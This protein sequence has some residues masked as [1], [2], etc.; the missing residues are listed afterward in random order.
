MQQTKLKH[1]TK[2]RTTIDTFKGYDHR[3]VIQDGS[4]YDEQNLSADQYPLLTVRK[5]RG[6]V[7]MID[8]VGRTD[9]PE[10]LALPRTVA[11]CGKEELL[12]LDEQG[13]LWSNNH[14]LAI[15]GGDY[16]ILV[17]CLGGYATVSDETKLLGALCAESG[18]GKMWTED[19]WVDAVTPGRHSFIFDAGEAKWVGDISG[20]LYTTADLGLTLPAGYVP[21][22]GDWLHAVYTNAPEL[23]EDISMISMGAWVAIWPWKIYVNAVMLAAGDTLTYDTDYGGME[24]HWGFEQ[25][26][27]DDPPH[28]A[29]LT[30]CDQ[31]GNTYENVHVANTSDQIPTAELWLDTSEQTRV[32]RQYSASLSTWVVVPDV[33]V[34]VTCDGIGEGLRAGDGVNVSFIGPAGYQATDRY[35]YTYDMLNS[36]HVVERVLDEDNIVLIGIFEPE[37]GNSET[38]TWS[39]APM[40]DTPF[41]KV[42]RNVPQMDFV[43]EAGNRLWG[44]YY[45][46]R[47]GEILNEIYAS[48]LGDFRNWNVFAGLSTDSYVA[49]RGADGP[50]TGAAVL[51]GHPL[52]F[53]ELGVEKVFPSATGAHQILTQTL[54]GVQKGS[55]RSTVVIDDKLYYKGVGGVYVYTGTLPTMISPQFGE[56]MYGS[57]CAGRH[58]KKYYISM[59]RSDGVWVLA[60]YDTLSGIWHMEDAPSQAD[61]PV[62]LVT[63]HSAVYFEQDG[64]ICVVDGGSDS[65]GVHWYAE[66]GVLGLDVPQRKYVSRINIR[67][68]RELGAAVRVYVQYDE[69][70]GWQ[71]KGELQGTRLYAGTLS[72]WPRRC[73]TFRLR[74]EGV[75]GFTL[76]S[77][78]WDRERGSDAF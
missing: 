19:G 56:I 36:A 45:G 15:I 69:G 21:S 28:E 47:D 74:F 50:Y 37:S 62:E 9:G 71:L 22:G 2:A 75:G 63:W 51:D 32:L 12:I 76:Y 70:T 29:T 18:A 42:D 68:K 26:P 55:G 43:V 16:E 61:P 57:A 5:N 52:F 13:V 72:I 48:A 38:L 17:S 31:E 4:W 54:E 24:N 44:C 67:Y 73:D 49:S 59:R 58:G 1:L 14:R 34:K 46:E 30:L 6:T 33:Y 3:P 40:R 60:C 23:P 66:T 35:K 10:L 64:E 78:T 20:N 27:G 65:R 41:F 8:L 7:S 53:R 77:V 11:F 25:T 39:G